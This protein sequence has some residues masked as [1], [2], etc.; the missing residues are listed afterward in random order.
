M[1]E[2]YFTYWDDLPEDSGFEL[3]SVTHIT[4]LIVIT[5]GILCGIK[6]YMGKRHIQKTKNTSC[7]CRYIGGHG[8]V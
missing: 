7:V 2:D 6:F 5:A 4:W 8:I 1:F 3:F